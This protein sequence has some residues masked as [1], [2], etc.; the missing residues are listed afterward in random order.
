MHHLHDPPRT[1]AEAEQIQDRLRPLLVLTEPG[2]Q[3]PRTIAGLDV[4]YAGDRLAAA[5]VVIDAAT[6]EVVEESVAEGSPAF[7]Y[8]PGLFAFR[9]LPALEKA[10]TRLSITPDLLVC[11]GHGLAHPRRFG[12]AC[13]LGV[14]TGLPSMG[15]AKNHLV[16]TYDP[17][18]SERGASSPLVD[19]G[20]VIDRVLR[21]QR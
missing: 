14:L 9:E 13:H 16:G 5:V 1:P 10:L 12:L 4:T 20:E 17:P 19:H 11:D 8:V 15:V 7:A 6:L 18:A 3:R 2:P 21:T